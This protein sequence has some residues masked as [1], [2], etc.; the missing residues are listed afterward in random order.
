MNRELSMT[1][2]GQDGHILPQASSGASR[3]P[4]GP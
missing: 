3:E 1:T 4:P 2:H